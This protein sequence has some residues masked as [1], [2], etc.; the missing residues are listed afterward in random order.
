MP[1]AQAAEGNAPTLPLPASIR[2]PPF[3][4][5][6]LLHYFTLVEAYLRNH[7]VTDEYVKSDILL[8][9]LPSEA[10]QRMASWL[11]SLEGRPTYAEFKREILAEY[12]L[13]EERR[14]EKIFNLY[15]AP[16]GDLTVKAAWKELEDLAE[17]PVTDGHGMPKKVD[18]VR[19][20]LLSRL[21]K[22]VRSAITRPHELPIKELVQKAEDLALS[23]EMSKDNSSKAFQATE[24]PPSDSS[25]EPVAVAASSR[26]P[27]KKRA[28]KKAQKTTLCVHHKLYGR[29][30]KTCEKP[31]QWVQPKNA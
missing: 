13:S 30:A 14:A 24:G 4:P 15:N 7:G 10:S 12:S 11:S 26:K 2:L 9:N 22:S 31:C 23:K 3:T 17:L 29:G 27:K 5:N 28:P 6:A 25:E 8:A 20:V 1:R 19:A 21:P 18:L 16:L